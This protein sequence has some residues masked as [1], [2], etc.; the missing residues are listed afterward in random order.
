MH[1]VLF[2][3]ISDHWRTPENL[4]RYLDEEFRFNFDPC[5]HEQL[6]TINGLL[7][8]WKNKIVFVNPPYFEVKKWV[9]KAYGEAR[10]NGATVVLLVP[11]RTD[12]AWFHDYCLKAEIRF[13]RGRLRFGNATENAPFPSML[14]IFRSN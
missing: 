13:I 3:S 9:A 4:Y 8:S 10:D 1:R 2:S 7:V 11:A 14:V 12:T 6:R 5:P